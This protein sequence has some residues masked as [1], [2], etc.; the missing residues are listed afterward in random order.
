MFVVCLFDSDEKKYQYFKR[1][2][3]KSSQSAAQWRVTMKWLS[4]LREERRTAEPSVS[5]ASFIQPD[6]RPYNLTSDPPPHGWD[7][8]PNQRDLAV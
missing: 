4:F 3:T 1:Q 5:T 6:L 2:V 8:T 7:P